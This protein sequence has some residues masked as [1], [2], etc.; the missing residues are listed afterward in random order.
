MD[1]I[2][3]VPDF[4]NL[5]SRPIPPIAFSVPAY[6]RTN[7]CTFKLVNA[8]FAVLLH[9]PGHILSDHNALAVIGLEA[10]SLLIAATFSRVAAVGFSGRRRRGYR[11]NTGGFLLWGHLLIGGGGLC[12]NGRA[13]QFDL[14]CDGKRMAD[15]ELSFGGV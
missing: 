9:R 2:F 5:F 12:C 14:G 1:N 7:T 3:N 13:R 6:T 11:P 8:S 15:R 4:A 10:L